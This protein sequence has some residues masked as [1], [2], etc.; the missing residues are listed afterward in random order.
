MCILR[1]ILV[2]LPCLLML[3]VTATTLFIMRVL[4]IMILVCAS[5]ILITP[6]IVNLVCESDC[7]LVYHS[8]LHEAY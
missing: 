1:L 7:A 4:L 2:L 3:R 8:V 5:M 6:M